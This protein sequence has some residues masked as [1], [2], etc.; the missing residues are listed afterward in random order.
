[1]ELTTKENGQQLTID[2]K[3]VD[4]AAILG[5]LECVEFLDYVNNFLTIE[6][7]KLDDCG[8][9]NTKETEEYFNIPHKKLIDGG[10]GKLALWYLILYYVRIG[11][12]Y[13]KER[14]IPANRLL[15]QK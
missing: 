6:K 13:Q 3:D 12:E 7:N 15:L 4:M 5:A 14:G 10:N 1:M 8:Y 9:Y 2:V 11:V